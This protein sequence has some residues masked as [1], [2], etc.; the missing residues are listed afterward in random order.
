MLARVVSA[1]LSYPL[2][3]VL[4]FLLVSSA[5]RAS[6]LTCARSSTGGFK[7]RGFS[8]SFSSLYLC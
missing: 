4:H 2:L 7:D 5:L 1:Y 8:H 3:I 6:S